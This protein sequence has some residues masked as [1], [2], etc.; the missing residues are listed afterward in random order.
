M[1]NKYVP[2]TSIE[3]VVEK[4]CDFFQESLL[5]LNTPDIDWPEGV[6]FQK[7]EIESVCA[8]Y[9]GKSCSSAAEQE[10]TIKSYKLYVII[11]S[12]FGPY[13]LLGQII[14]AF[15]NYKRPFKDDAVTTDVL[16][17][18]HPSKNLQIDAMLK[19]V[20]LDQSET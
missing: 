8:I 10:K 2:K 4:G 15:L 18:F 16:G 5:L 12:L 20:Y 3:S 19:E 1:C 17:N 11:T 9:C 7:K 13:G 6:K 14:S